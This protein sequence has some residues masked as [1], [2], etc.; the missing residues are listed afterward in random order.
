VRVVQ[1]ELRR[2]QGQAQ[3]WQAEKERLEET[4]RKTEEARK[5]VEAESESSQS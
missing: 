2:L 3:G 5:T 1:E 4:R